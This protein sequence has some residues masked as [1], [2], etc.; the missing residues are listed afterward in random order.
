MCSSERVSGVARCGIIVVS[1]DSEHPY[2]RNNYIRCMIQ[3]KGT[4]CNI[5]SK[6]CWLIDQKSIAQE[7][8][9]AVNWLT[10]LSGEV[11]K[12]LRKLPFVSTGCW[13]NGIMRS[14]YRIF[15]RA[16]CLMIYIRSMTQKVTNHLT[17][18]PPLMC[19]KV[20]IT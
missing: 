9:A 18:I 20:R 8:N 15:E 12:L 2:S 4:V 11:H 16:L 3:S 10:W 13:W 19:H 14:K 17:I 6:W 5:T 1:T 7:S